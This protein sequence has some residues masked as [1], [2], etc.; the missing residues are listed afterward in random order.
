[1]T[2]YNYIKNLIIPDTANSVQSDELTAIELISTIPAAQPFISFKCTSCEHMV[3]MLER[4]EPG[5]AAVIQCDNCNVLWSIMCPPLEVIPLDKQ[6]LLHKNL[7][8][9]AKAFEN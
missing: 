5:E 2:L 6:P 9:I 7:A 3:D 4:V 1:M 8:D